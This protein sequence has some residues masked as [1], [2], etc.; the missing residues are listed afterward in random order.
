MAD[1]EAFVADTAAGIA[2]DVVVASAVAA[3]RAVVEQIACHNSNKPAAP[4][5]FVHHTG[6]TGISVAFLA[7]LSPQQILLQ[8]IHP[9][10]IKQNII[11]K[12]V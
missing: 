1:A 2:A 11:I 8:I 7:L 4:D 3:N 12:Q 9:D 5:N 6:D 10:R